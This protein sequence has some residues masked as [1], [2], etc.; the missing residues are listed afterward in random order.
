MFTRLPALLSVLILV[1]L[2]QVASAKA[3]SKAKPAPRPAPSAPAPAPAPTPGYDE[4]GA[5]YQKGV[6]EFGAGH[7]EDAIV[8]FKLALAAGGPPALLFNIAQA[9]RLAGNDREALGYYKEYLR[10]AP[11][12][13][14]RSDVEA[15]M[16]AIQQELDSESRAQRGIPP[17][18][19]PATADGQPPGTAVADAQGDAPLPV[20]LSVREASGSMLEPTV[21]P[22]HPGRKLEVAGVATMG[23]GVVILGMG[24]YFGVQAANEA[25]ELD[26]RAARGETWTE[27]SQDLYDRGQR[28]ET[29]GYSLAIGGGAALLTGAVLTYIGFSQDEQAAEFAFVPTRGG[30]Q[31]VMAWDF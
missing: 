8:E 1:A 29:L 19:V 10:V 28:H 15:R 20:D 24:V 2:P 14:N 22:Y 9:H 6:E 26:A 30:A 11:D 16:T 25:D 23:A 31:A 17:R 27:D 5:H 12:A 3:R 21:A 13:P 4:A 18:P 7:Y